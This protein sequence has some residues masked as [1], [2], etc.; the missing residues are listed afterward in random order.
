[1]FLNLKFLNLI[2]VTRRVEYRSTE[3]QRAFLKGVSC[4]FSFWMCL[5]GQSGGFR[6][7]RRYS[8]GG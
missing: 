5:E 2:D 8:P 6:S 4:G 7:I 1:M 3:K